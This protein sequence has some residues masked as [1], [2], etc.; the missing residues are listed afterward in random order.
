[1]TQT[2]R[3]YDRLIFFIAVMAGVAS[4]GFSHALPDDSKQNMSIDSNTWEFDIQSGT[5]TFVGKVELQQGSLKINADKL[6]IYGKFEGG[7][8]ESAQKIVATGKPAK[9][10]QTPRKGE[11]PVKAVANRL[12]YSVKNET[13]FLIDKAHLDQDGTS[14]SGNKIE[15]DVQKALVKAGSKKT[16][17]DDRVRMVIPP[18]V[19]QNKE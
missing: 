1:M 17:E 11:T 9:F 3:I 8:P 2:K 18:K 7:R 15:Y 6:V 14:L 4:T 10:Q 12:E 16:D 19:I 13:L 5:T